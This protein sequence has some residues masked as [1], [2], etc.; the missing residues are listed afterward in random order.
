MSSKQPLLLFAVSL[1]AGIVVQDYF[2]LDKRWLFLIFFL[3]FFLFLIQ[4]FKRFQFLK[5]SI[6]FLVFACGMLIHGF[7]SKIDSTTIKDGKRDLVFELKKKLNSNE[8]FRKYEVE[9]YENNTKIKSVLNVPKEYPELN[10][11]NE[12]RANVFV[13]KVEKPAYGFQF[14]YQ[15]FLARKDIFYVS[16]F[17]NGL[18]C[19]SKSMTIEE[20]VSQ[21][22]L[23]MLGN[24]NNSSISTSVKQFLKG[25]ILADRTEMNSD[26]V[27][28]FNRSG[29]THF[30]AISG[31]HVII[32]F[33]MIMWFFTKVF[34]AKFRKIAIVLSVLLIWLFVGF[35][36]WGNSVVRS[37]IMLSVYIIF[38]L[39]E[40][41]PDL[42]HS[43]SLS[44]I[45][46]LAINSQ[47][48]FDVGFQLSFLAVLGIYWLNQPILDLLPYPKNI[49]TKI[50]YNTFSMTLSAQFATLPIVLYYFHQFSYI[51]FIS[52]I[53]IVPFSEIVIVFSFLMT[54][55]LG[56][57][58]EF[59][60]LN[61]IYD[62]LVNFL[63]KAIHG[64]ASVDFTFYKS[65]SFSQLEVISAFLMVFF[66]GL[67]LKFKTP[68][69]AFRLIGTIVLFLTIRVSLNLKEDFINETAVFEAK[70]EKVLMIRHGRSAK[71][72]VSKPNSNLEKFLIEPYASNSR[73]SDYQINVIPE[74]T[75]AVVFNGKDYRL[76][77]D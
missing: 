63:L 67:F 38:E 65:I 35:I 10:F 12:Y 68:K 37:C 49:F 64:F 69:E 13:K 62:G 1:I 7:N 5:F 4:F 39:L 25:I 11:K 8:K 34:P 48:L 17:Q 58:I 50:I 71:F 29:L 51:S 32:I 21:K 6:Y 31:T 56:F 36:G 30:L 75:K 74:G 24:I 14:N 19:S 43:L 66:L 46:I 57:G 60:F 72:Y 76:N 22:R 16:Y 42:L 15:K 70:K 33:G 2:E 41:K 26:L 61:S 44:A 53:F 77:E 73:I 27:L 47:E 40:R 52:N 9:F 28:D 18:K 54:F 20:S 3:G 45:I 55:I 59:P 23:E